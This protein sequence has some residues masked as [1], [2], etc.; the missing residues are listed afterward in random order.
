MAFHLGVQKDKQII[1]FVIIFVALGILASFFARQCQFLSTCNE[2]NYNPAL[3][4]GGQ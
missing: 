3:I 2:P 1:A 4:T